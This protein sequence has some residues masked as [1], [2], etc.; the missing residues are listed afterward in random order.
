MQLWVVIRR[1]GVARLREHVQVSIMMA[2]HFEGLVG[3]NPRFE[4][5][6]PKRLSLVC[7]RLKP[8]V[9]ADGTELNMKFLEVINSTSHA[10]LIHTLIGGMYVLRFAIGGTL[11]ELRH[12]NATWNLIQE[13]ADLVEAS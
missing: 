9:E 13:N 7:F 10:F 3:A 4:V 2:K 1:F 5:V 12:F 11:I 8:K 6:V